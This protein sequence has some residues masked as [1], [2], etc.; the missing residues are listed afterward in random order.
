MSM[1][2]TIARINELYH[3]SQ[4]RPLSEEEKEEQAA[5]R[6]VYIDSVKG[7][8]SSQLD[9]MS[10]VRPDGTVEKVTKKS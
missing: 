4:E 9:S 1:N 8:L 7:N 2:E 6:R 3:L 5:L 10:I